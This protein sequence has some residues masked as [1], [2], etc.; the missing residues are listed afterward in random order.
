[1]LMKTCELTCHFC[2]AWPH[3]K[4]FGSGRRCRGTR[5]VMGDEQ[6][7]CSSTLHFSLVIMNGHSASHCVVHTACF[8]VRAAAITTSSG[9]IERRCL[10]P[11]TSALFETGLDSD[12]ASHVDGQT[13]SRLVLLPIIVCLAAGRALNLSITRHV[14][15]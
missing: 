5:G 4:E 11:I 8:L 15:G 13:L 7:S 2:T 9:G 10:A 1:M 12:E 6:A 14:R 3:F